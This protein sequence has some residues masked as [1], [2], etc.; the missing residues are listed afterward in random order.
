M[1]NKNK[2][3]FV[4][5]Y[6]IKGVFHLAFATLAGLI[7]LCLTF[8]KQQRWNNSRSIASKWNV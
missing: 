5:T 3:I 2:T 7:C 4:S 1:S 8:D 6:L